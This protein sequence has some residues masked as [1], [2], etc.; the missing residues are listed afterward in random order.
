MIAEGY[1]PM[2]VIQSA[3]QSVADGATR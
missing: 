1:A 3:R 2:Q